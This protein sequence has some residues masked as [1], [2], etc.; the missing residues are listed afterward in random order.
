[1]NISKPYSICPNV[2][3]EAPKRCHWRNYSAVIITFRHDITLL[4]GALLFIPHAKRYN[5]HRSRDSKRRTTFIESFLANYSKTTNQ[6]FL[7]NLFDDCFNLTSDI[8][9]A[10]TRKPDF[11]VKPGTFAIRQL[12]LYLAGIF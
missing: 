2:L 6:L 7:K 8:F 5:V 9:R 1:M 12:C 3:I 11:F 4:L 10:K